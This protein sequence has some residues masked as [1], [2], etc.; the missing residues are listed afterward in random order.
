M[1]YLLILILN[2]IDVSAITL[3]PV[4]YTTHFQLPITGGR[5]VAALPSKPE[6]LYLQKTY[7][8]AEPKT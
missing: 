1:K 8:T 4:N 7:F 2:L 6:E 3:T 5:G